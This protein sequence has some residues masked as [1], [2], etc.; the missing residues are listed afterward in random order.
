MNSH[1]GDYDNLNSSNARCIVGKLDTLL[2]KHNEL[3]KFFKLNI[4]K[5]KSANHA[6]VINPDNTLSGEYVRRFNASVVDDVGGIMVGD[7][8][9]IPKI[10]IGKRNNNLEFIDDTHR[11][12]D[13]LQYQLIFWKGQDGCHINIKKRDP[14]TGNSFIKNII[15]QF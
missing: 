6:V 15:S 8:T 11:S 13:A 3:W 2:N 1:C 14:A 10:V 12:Y 5:L 4:N 9:T 7:L